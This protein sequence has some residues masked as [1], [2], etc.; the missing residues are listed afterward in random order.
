MITYTDKYTM[1]RALSNYNNKTH[2]ERR[3]EN[4]E[5]LII[6]HH[7]FHTLFFYDCKS[8]SG[9]VGHPMYG[10]GSDRRIL[11]ARREEKQQ[12]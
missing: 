8:T 3:V 4:R 1:I 10:V 12:N 9:L 11:I 5:M 6:F 7:V 2:S